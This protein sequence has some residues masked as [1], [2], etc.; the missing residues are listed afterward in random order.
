MM[1][2]LIA[3]QTI[4]IIGF[5]RIGRHVAMLL[6]AFGARVLVYDKC[7]VLPFGNVKFVALEHLLQDSD[8]VTLHLP[9]DS[10]THHIINEQ[11]LRLMKSTA[12]LVN[13]ARGGLIDENALYA[14]MK[15]KRLAGVALDCFEDEPYTGALLSCDNV[16]M[17]SHMGSY[18]HETR[19]I[20]EAEAC[21]ALVCG[22]RKSGLLSQKDQVSHEY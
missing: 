3:K 9:Y 1:G 8:I 10:A 5:G 16:Q 18:A 12:L 6:E 2:R 21:A 17:T 22:L 14:A 20:M 4:G 19:A 7:A 11:T 15:E 13:V